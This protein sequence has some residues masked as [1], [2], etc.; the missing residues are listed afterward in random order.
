[1]CSVSSSVVQNTSWQTLCSLVIWKA[2]RL[3]KL[4]IHLLPHCSLISSG[5]NSKP[6]DFQALWLILWCAVPFPGLV[7][8]Q[9]SGQKN[10]KLSLNHSIFRPM[11]LSITVTCLTAIFSPRCLELTQMHRCW[12]SWDYPVSVCGRKG[13][14]KKKSISYSKKKIEF[15]FFPTQGKGWKTSIVLVHDEERRKTVGEQ[16][17]R[18]NSACA[19]WRWFSAAG[20]FCLL[21]LA[22]IS[23]ILLWTTRI[24]VRA[25]CFE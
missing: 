15:I 2:L 1:M 25:F 3:W 21:G 24:E 10:S 12:G 6:Q 17:G 8:R 16:R 4:S 7:T 23:A 5:F 13:T 19:F 11:P 20:I 9:S 22:N 14:R 18:A